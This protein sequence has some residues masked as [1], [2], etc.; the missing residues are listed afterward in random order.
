M[1]IPLLDLVFPEAHVNRCQL[2]Q[3]GRESMLQVREVMNAHDIIV[4]SH[5]HN[6]L[7]PRIPVPTEL[8]IPQW[9]CRL[10]NYNDNE[11]VDFL[12][13]GWPIGIEGTP[14]PYGTPKNHSGANWIRTR[15]DSIW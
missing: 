10:Q 4:R 14:T 2:C 7:G 3:V 15:L 13:F 11:V 12:Q 1:S 9:R 5:M 8:N 6:Y